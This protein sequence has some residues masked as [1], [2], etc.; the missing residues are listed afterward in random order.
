MSNKLPV[1]A[2]T[3]LTLTSFSSGS[4]YANDEAKDIYQKGVK[5]FVHKSIGAVIDSTIV[6]ENGD[7]EKRAFFLAKKDHDENKNSILIRF[8]EPDELKCTSVLVNSE[9]EEAKRY[10]YFP[11]IKRVRIIPES[12]KGKEVF[13]IGISYEDLGIPEGEFDQP[14]KLTNEAG[15]SLYKLTLRDGSKTSEYLINADSYQL[16]QMNVYKQEVLQKSVKI[17]DIQPYFGD[18]L[19]TSWDIHYPQTNRTIYYSIRPDSVTEKL[20]SSLFHKNKLKRCKI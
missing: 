16:T 18:D 12:E 8:L 14:E 19:I 5:I 10:A 1:L 7:E 20:K 2:L 6:Y 15:V 13:G 11:A 17:N 9:G 4:I 3:A